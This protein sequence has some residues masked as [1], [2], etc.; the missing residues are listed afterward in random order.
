MEP[1]DWGPFSEGPS[2]TV[3]N[4]CDFLWSKPDFFAASP[5]SEFGLTPIELA[6]TN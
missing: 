2:M 1:I 6:L 5:H 4:S 3:K